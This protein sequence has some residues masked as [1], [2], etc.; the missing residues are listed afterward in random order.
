MKI[1]MKDMRQELKDTNSTVGNKLVPVPKEE[2]PLA[3]KFNEELQRVWR[4]RKFLVQEHLEKG[5][6]RL[7]VIDASKI[8]AFGKQDYKFGD[9][10]TWDDLQRIKAEVGYGDRCAV[11][12]YPPDSLIVNVK[13]MRHLWI[14]DEIPPYCWKD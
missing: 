2:R 10:I 13:N 9:S 3:M 4:S 11:E 8:K 12:V 5:V 14:L 6:I 1:N 7:S